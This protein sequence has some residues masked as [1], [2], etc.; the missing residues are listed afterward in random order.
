MIEARQ[1]P[2]EWR[3]EVDLVANDLYNIEKDMELA[4]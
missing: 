4:K 3:Q 2:L 1:D